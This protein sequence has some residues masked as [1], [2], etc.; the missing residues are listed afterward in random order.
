MQLIIKLLVKALYNIYKGEKRKVKQL[1]AKRDA[2][3]VNLQ[4]KAEVEQKTLDNR[5]KKHLETIDKLDRIAEGLS[6]IFSE[7]E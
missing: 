5:V 1:V 4:A 2:I 3:L 7:E 6:D